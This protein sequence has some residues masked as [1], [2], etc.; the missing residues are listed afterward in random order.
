[1]RALAKLSRSST[2]FQER[3]EYDHPPLINV[4]VKISIIFNHTT[5]TQ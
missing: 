3:L 2:G 5:T 1:M 4:N